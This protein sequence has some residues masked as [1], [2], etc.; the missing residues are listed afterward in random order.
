MG[1][2][3][4]RIF[5]LGHYLFL[6]AHDQKTTHFRPKSGNSFF[7]I[8]LSLIIFSQVCYLTFESCP[9][10]LPWTLPMVTVPQFGFQFTYTRPIL[11]SHAATLNLPINLS[12]LSVLSHFFRIQTTVEEIVRWISRKKTRGLFCS[13]FTRFTSATQRLKTA[14][15][16]FPPFHTITSC[17]THWNVIQT[18]VTNMTKQRMLA[19]KTLINDL[20]FRMPQHTS[21]EVYLPT[22]TP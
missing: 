5:V 3:Y 20:R 13:L 8:K 19:K 4:A 10:M 14:P 15:K 9:F 22:L 1:R 18:A 11:F 16:I 7:G 2:K 17:R 21:S 6:E 12:P